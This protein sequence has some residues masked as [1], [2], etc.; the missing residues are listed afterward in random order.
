MSGPILNT[1]ELKRLPFARRPI[2]Q[3]GTVLVFQMP[4]NQLVA[5]EPPYT[6]GETWWKGPKLAYVVDNRP[7]GGSF[8]C[9][10]PAA[11]DA[12]FF[13]ATVRFSWRVCDAVAVVRQ[14]VGDPD[15]DCE[16][17]LTQHLPTI[18]R[19][20]QYNKPAD[21]E[22]DV[23]N[24]VGGRALRL[25]NRGI[26]IDAVH[27]QLRIAEERVGVIADIGALAETSELER[28]RTEHALEIQ[29]LKRQR[30]NEIVSGGPERLYAFILQ[31][32]PAKGMEVVS[33]MQAM[34]DREKQRA[35]EAIKV[36]IDGEEIRVGELDGAVA[37]AV[38][39]F[40]NILGQ[41]AGAPDAA[42]QP[43]ELTAGDDGEA[44]SESS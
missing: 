12:L 31:E 30:M 27:V 23:V 1:M 37:A 22:A 41:Y 9:R 7:H 36:L 17:Y 16:A 11:G 38:D 20:H 40:K 5:P 18:T 21:A 10:L 28:L 8:G 3:P 2:A 25:P 32:D 24:T 29:A 15:G 14:Q 43:A 44:G 13:D 42:G 6:T 33:Q 39:G 34:A 35:I 4:D 26:Q 19:R